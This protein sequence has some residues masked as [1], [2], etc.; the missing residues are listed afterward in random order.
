LTPKTWSVPYLVVEQGL[1]GDREAAVLD[2]APDAVRLAVGSLEPAR[3]VEE[4]LRLEWVAGRVADHHHARLQA[5]LQVLRDDDADLA[6]VELHR[7]AEREN[8]DAADELLDQ[9]RVEEAA[10]PLVQ[11]AERG[12]RRH[13]LGVGPARGERIEGVDDAGDRAEQPDAP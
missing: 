3:Q 8:A 9:H 1:G 11:H 5:F 4:L 13:R 10:A 7:A 12:R 6:A 2:C